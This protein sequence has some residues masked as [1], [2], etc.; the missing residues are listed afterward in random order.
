MKDSNPSFAKVLQMLLE[1]IKGYAD[2]PLLSFDTLF[3]EQTSLD[4]C[5]LVLADVE[6]PELA[7]SY[8]VSDLYCQ[9]PSCDCQKVSLV[10]FD[11]QG[12]IHATIAYGWKSA[13][14]YRKW[15]CDPEVIPS[16]TQGFLDPWAQQSPNANLFLK[17]FWRTARNNPQFISR[18]KRRYALFKETITEN[19]DQIVPYPEVELPENVI[20]FRARKVG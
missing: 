18:L 20:P 19:P 6:P 17:A 2:L 14:F 5:V 8:G 4:R 7:G 16:L 10:V 1:E 13:T 3:P 12:K 15:G 11:N 9:D